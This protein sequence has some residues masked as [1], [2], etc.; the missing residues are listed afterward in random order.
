MKELQRELGQVR[1][2][3]HDLTE[4]LDVLARS[5]DSGMT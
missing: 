4:K 1:E 2:Q 5:G 3:V